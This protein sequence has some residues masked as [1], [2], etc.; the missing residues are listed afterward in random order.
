[1]TVLDSDARAEGVTRQELAKICVRKIREAVERYRQDRT[2][3][4]IGLGVLWSVIATIVLALSLFLTRFLFRKLQEGVIETRIADRIG[5]IQIQSFVIVKA[6]QIK[7]LLAGSARTARLVIILVL[8]FIYAQFVLSF[9]P[10]TRPI[11]SHLLD[12]LLVPLAT[13]GKGFLKHIPNL[14]FLGVLVFVTNYL[15]KLMRLF[16]DGL[17]SGTIAF[18]GFYP[19]WAKPT[20]PTPWPA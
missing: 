14:I 7:A 15:L 4:A 5:S 16:F 1:M 11:A 18:S 20:Y 13:M 3:R 17:E 10:W 19:E 2:P 12:F 8:L 6:D 9:Y